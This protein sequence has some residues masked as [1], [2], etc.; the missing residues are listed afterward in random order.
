MTTKYVELCLDVG[1]PV[2]FAKMEMA[3][4]ETE[5]GKVPQEP[6]AI[7]KM[8]EKLSLEGQCLPRLTEKGKKLRKRMSCL[9]TAARHKLLKD[10]KM[11]GK[12]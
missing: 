11:P 10:N 9:K 2:R 5:V 12:K 7:V 4:L 1:L 3:C 8:E 6:D